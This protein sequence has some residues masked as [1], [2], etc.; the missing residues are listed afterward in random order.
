MPHPAEVDER[1]RAHLRS[2]LG[3]WPP[4]RPVHVVGSERRVEPGWDGAVRALNGVATPDGAVVSVPPAAE[5][6][7]ATVVEELEADGVADVLAAL[8][9]RLAD[10]LDLPGARYGAGVFRWST[11]PTASDDPGTWLPRSDPRVP[12]WLHPFNGDVLV[13][14]ADD[15]SVA[16]GVGRKQHDPHG[17]EL[18]VVTEEAHRGQGFARRLVTQAARRVLADDAVPVYLHAESNVASARTADASG[19]PD[20]GWRILG[21]FGGAAGTP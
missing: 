6:R 10:L 1:L 20:V 11:E 16:A 9:E 19:F 13:A 2:W 18:A 7:I 8:G 12:E 17:H 14:L 5:A 15:G 3:A 4:A 21:L